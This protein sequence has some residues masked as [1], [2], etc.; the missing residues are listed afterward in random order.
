ME[1]T[2]D[3]PF[4][5]LAEVVISVCCM[6]NEL[7]ET[8]KLLRSIDAHNP[9]SSEFANTPASNAPANENEYEDEY[10]NA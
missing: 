6:G 7:E 4:A 10:Q 9:S 5:A 2:S 3:L 8:A 1:L